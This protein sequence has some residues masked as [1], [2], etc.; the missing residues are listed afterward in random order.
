M[1]SLFGDKINKLIKSTNKRNY[2]IIAISYSNDLYLRQISLNKKSALEAGEVDKHYS[3]GPNDLDKDFIEKNKEILKKKRGNG[4]WLWKPYIIN[5]TM[6]EKL[7]EG[8]YLIY[9]DACTIYM[10]SSRLLIDFLE[11]N[12]ASFWMNKVYFK[13]RIWSKRD[14]FLIMDADKPFFSD[15]P[16][17]MAGIQLYKKTEYSIKFIKEWLFYCQDIRIISDNKNTLGKK[18][19][20]DFIENRHDQTALSLLIKKYG[21]SNSG[22]INMSINEVLK[23]K[24]II[25][26]N[27]ICIYRRIPFNDYEDLKSKCKK[28]IIKQN[29]L[30][31]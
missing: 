21:E 4:Y 5:K 7:N 1:Y 20:K 28:I 6:I 17:Y 13:E 9:T 12:N 29:K 14:A 19:Y 30:F 16:Q 10:N 3:Y 8:D 2:K 27:I 18:N 24:P 11:K 22:N 31:T 15:T 25:M 26:P 23:L